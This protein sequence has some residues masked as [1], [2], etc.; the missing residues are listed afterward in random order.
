MATWTREELEELYP[1]GEVNVQV[2]NA[3]RPMTHEEWDT[4]IEGQVGVEKMEEV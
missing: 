3:V 4:W 2:D 1:E